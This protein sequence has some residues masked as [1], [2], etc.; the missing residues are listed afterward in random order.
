M[1]LVNILLINV[2]IMVACFMSFSNAGMSFKIPGIHKHVDR[3]MKDIPAML[4]AARRKIR[5]IK[6][7]KSIRP[8][9]LA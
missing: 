8:P 5:H 1:R 2:L 9:T 7:M 6:K 3:N 4:E